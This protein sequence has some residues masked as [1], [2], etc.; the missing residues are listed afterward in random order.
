M[1]IRP[2]RDGATRSSSSQTWKPGLTFLAS[3]KLYYFEPVV[4][5]PQT[6]KRWSTYITNR[7]NPLLIT[8][9]LRQR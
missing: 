3:R 4:R 7:N 1:R 2:R 6:Q 8:N 9:I 5:V